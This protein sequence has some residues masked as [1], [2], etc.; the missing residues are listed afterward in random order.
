MARIAPKWQY[1]MWWDLLSQALWVVMA[2]TRYRF[3]ARSYNMVLRFSREIRG[4]GKGLS[5]QTR[6]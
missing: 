6:K 1:A 3:R 2:A 5:P 4:L